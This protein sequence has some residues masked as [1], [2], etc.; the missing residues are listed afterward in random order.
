MPVSTAQSGIGGMCWDDR[1]GACV[2]VYSLVC[3]HVVRLLVDMVCGQCV[4]VCACVRVVCVRVRAY[5]RAYVHACVRACVR[6]CVCGKCLCRC[7]CCV[8]C[9]VCVVRCVCCVRLY[10][11]LPVQIKPENCSRKESTR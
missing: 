10:M 8:V 5:V 9:A 7:V 2:V 1:D 6:A 4:C 11:V 3:M